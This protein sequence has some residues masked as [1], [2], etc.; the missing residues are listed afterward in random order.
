[1]KEKNYS[2]KKVKRCNPKRLNDQLASFRVGKIKELCKILATER[3]I[4]FVDECGINLNHAL[5]YGWAPKGETLWAF[6]GPKRKHIS[7]IMA[8]TKYH[9]SGYMFCDGPVTKE[10]FK[11]FLGTLIE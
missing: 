3:T 1:M 8:M 7:L 11:L 4:V 6:E 5:E 9:V 2:Y 10:T